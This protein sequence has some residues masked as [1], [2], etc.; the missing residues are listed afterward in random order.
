MRASVPVLLDL[1]VPGP[2][3]V[4]VLVVIEEAGLD[5]VL[6]TGHHSRGSLLNLELLFMGFRGGGIASNHLLRLVN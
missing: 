5:L 2:L 1:K 3:E 6:A 4:D